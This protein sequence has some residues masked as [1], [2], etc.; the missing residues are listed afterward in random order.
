M[1]REVKL[2]ASLA[3][4]L[5]PVAL[6]LSAC[7][8]KANEDVVTYVSGSNE[9]QQKADIDAMTAARSAQVAMETYAADNGGTYEGA[10]GATLAA[11]DPTLAGQAVSVSAT[12]TGYTV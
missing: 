1:A 10:S 2:R 3:A 4:A 12:S 8:G 11:T 9:R 5:V 6:A 7:G